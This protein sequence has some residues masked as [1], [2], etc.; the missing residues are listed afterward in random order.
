MTEPGAGGEVTLYEADRN[1]DV[2]LVDISTLRTTR[3]DLVKTIEDGVKAQLG[4]E[5][6]KTME[7]EALIKEKD[8]QIATLTTERDALKEAAE[9]A[10]KATAKAEAQA[11]I[12]E[13]VDKAELPDAAK[14]RLLERFKDAEN[15]DEIVEAIESEVAYIAKLSE[16][17][18]VKGLGSASAPT[19]EKDHEAL[20]ESFGRMGMDKESAEVAASGR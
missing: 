5:V 7:N 4:K 11:T 3:P 10:E 13:A 17:G 14:E 1:H 19:L 16:A 18:K 15:A 20:V 9:K 8:E 12:K 2:D 6:K